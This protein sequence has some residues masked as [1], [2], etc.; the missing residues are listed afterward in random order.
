MVNLCWVCA[1]ERG[2]GV[3]EA[4]RLTAGEMGK[5][6]DKGLDFILKAVERK[7]FSSRG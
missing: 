2:T 5:G 4:V 1:C 6:Q 3:G 7:R